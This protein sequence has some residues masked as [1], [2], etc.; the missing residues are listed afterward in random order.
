[1]S[2]QPE[3][4]R[5]PA[6]RQEDWPAPASDE[7]SLFD[8]WEVLVRRRALVAAVFGACVALALAWGLARPDTFQYTGAVSVG[9]VPGNGGFTSIQSAQALQAEAEQAHIP[10]VLRSEQVPEGERQGLEISASVP[11]SGSLVVLRAEGAEERAELYLTLLGRVAERLA[12]AYREPFEAS[13][14]SLQERIQE[15]QQ[16]GEIETRRAAE[17]AAR[18]QAIE[19][20]QETLQQ[21]ITGLRERL[22]ANP[23]APALQQAL[24][25]ALELR[26]LVLPERF[27]QAQSERF[28]AERAAAQARRE[29][30]TSRAQL[31]A[32]RPVGLL[33]PPSRSLRPTG[34]G[35][36]VILA[37]GAVLGVMVGVFAAFGAEFVRRAAVAAGRE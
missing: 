3:P 23:E 17:A 19:A 7:I 24:N 13:R 4:S 10:A 37:L 36:A 5:L 26:D 6:T 8:L 18:V 31:S 25:R 15:L 1:M 30:Q 27:R 22:E 28:Q 2:T 16:T 9:R 32:L 35:T 21:E 20:R 29:I 12:A 34:P 14:T 33:E 11:D